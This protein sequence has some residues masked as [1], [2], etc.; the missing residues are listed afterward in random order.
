M[1]KMFLVGVILISM[2]LIGVAGGIIIPILTPTNIVIEYPVSDPNGN[3]VKEDMD[4]FNGLQYEVFENHIVLNKPGVFKEKRIAFNPK[5]TCLEWTDINCIN[6][7]I[8]D[9]N[10]L[11][12]SICLEYSISEC[13]KWTSFTKLEL[14]ESTIKIELERIVAIQKNRLERIVEDKNEF[15]EI[16]IISKK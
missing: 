5:Q 8:I 3:L 7:S 13:N 2:L 1:N 6:Y 15:G 9:K 16:S 10:S 12:E 14:I 11:Y 4:L